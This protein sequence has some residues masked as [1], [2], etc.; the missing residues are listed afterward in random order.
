MKLLN[1]FFRQYD[2]KNILCLI[3]LLAHSVSAHASLQTAESFMVQGKPEEAFTA[4]DPYVMKNDPHALYLMG[5]I[6]LSQASKQFNQKKGIEFLERA[7]F[8]NYGPALDELA[9]L[10][11][12]GEG[13]EKNEAKALHYYTQ[14]SH[15]GYGPSQFN[16]GIMHKE[17]QGTEKNLEKAYLYLSLASL[18][19]KDLGD[20]TID[21][22]RH[23]DEI[24]PFLNPTQRQDILRL[25]NDLTL[26]I[27]PPKRSKVTP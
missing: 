12:A 13:V 1:P 5:V 26:P 2:K 4:L 18:N 17:G 23:R 11:L 14:S 6:Y 25:V 19:H 8:Q 22:A 3:F 10:Y 7:V 24:V 15:L 20:V 9:G 16:C 27:G 21:A